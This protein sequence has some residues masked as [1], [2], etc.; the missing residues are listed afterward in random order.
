MSNKEFQI[1]NRAKDLLIYTM[2]VAKPV[3]DKSI[4]TKDTLAM[5][6]RIS[7][8][9]PDEVKAFCEDAAERIRKSHKKQGFPK[10]AQNTLVN[11]IRNAVHE[12]V[13]Y[14]QMANDVNFATEY[15]KRLEYIDEILKRCNLVL[16]LI[17]VSLELKYISVKRSE[18]WTK[19][20]LDVKY[21]AL[22]WR[23]KDSARATEL[24]E[25]DKAAEHKR[26][27]QLVLQ[28]LQEIKGCSM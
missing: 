22:S 24:R 4:D 18:A 17:S 12:I 9:S 23:R 1:A 28:S 16:M 11:P 25:K 2:K 19:Y 14:V 20:V 27:A 26:L 13:M 8:M 6:T 10:S 3:G 21:M 5:L 15:D 7:L